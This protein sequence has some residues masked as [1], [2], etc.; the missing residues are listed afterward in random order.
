MES[1]FPLLSVLLWLPLFGALFVLFTPRQ[2][3][4][5]IRNFTL[6]FT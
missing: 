2:S 1:G 3:P 6:A 5:S 4:Q